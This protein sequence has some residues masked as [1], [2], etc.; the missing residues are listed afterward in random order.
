MDRESS[1]V[2]CRH[3]SRESGAVGEGVQT[4]HDW[5]GVQLNVRIAES[6]NRRMTQHAE[7][8]RASQPPLPAK[9]IGYKEIGYLE[10]N[11]QHMRY[12]ED[13]A[14]GYLIGSG[15]IGGRLPSCGQRSHGTEWHAMD[16]R[17]CPGDASH[18]FHLPQLRRER[19]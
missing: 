11:R 2:D 17:R 3:V 9:E 19:I 4:L 18:P 10:N 7:S 14:A 16:R 5:L 6:I 12:D 1:I 8:Y 15:V 13:L